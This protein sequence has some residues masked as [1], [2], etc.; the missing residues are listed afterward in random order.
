MKSIRRSM[1]A[2]LVLSVGLM[3]RAS[4]GDGVKW[5]YDYNAARIEAQQAG[6]PLLIDFS[7]EWC[8]ACKKLDV[9]TFRDPAVMRTLSEQFIC[10]KLDGDREKKLVE[11]LRIKFYPTLILAG[12]DGR[13][14]KTIE[15]F[16]EAER[17]RED[18]RE[19]VAAVANP[20]WMQR[21]YAEAARAVAAGDFARATVLLQTILEDQQQRPV[22]RQAEQLLQE[23]EA[24]AHTQLAFARHMQERAQYLEAAE[25]L[26][27]LVKS[28]AGTRAAAEAAKSLA[29]LS[30]RPEVKTQQRC[31]RAAEFLAQ[32]KNDFNARQFVCCLDRCEVLVVSFGDLPEGV[33]AKQLLEQ[34]K[35]NPE[36]MKAACDKTAERLG[37]LYLALADTWLLKGEDQLAAK[38]LEQVTLLLPGS[39]HAQLAKTRLGHLRGQ[40][41]QSAEFE[42]PR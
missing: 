40:P 36:W 1:L 23:I 15:G 7:T 5:R 38:C 27:D 20:E 16:K 3:G 30:D 14:L 17:F 32:A 2:T 4:A 25:R 18:L 34:I 21:N 10:V 11:T 9:T 39:P 12:P 26:S 37:E 19:A 41:T 29:A 22:R 24:K 35:A 28:Y 33:E 6:L 13:I 42:K 8:A 31:W